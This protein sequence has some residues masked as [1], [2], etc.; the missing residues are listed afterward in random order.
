MGIDIKSF[1]ITATLDRY[2]YMRMPLDV[3]V[4]P[5]HVRDQYDLDRKAKNGFVYLEIRRAIYGLPQ[6]GALANKLLREQLAPYGY[7]EVAHTPGL[8]RHVTCPISFSLMLLMILELRMLVTNMH[9][10]SLMYSK[11]GINLQKIGMAVFI[12]VLTWIG[13]MMNK[14]WISRC[15]HIF[16]TE[17]LDTLW[18]FQTNKTAT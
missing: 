3:D 6:S 16:R 1:F 11:N 2:K 7:Y 5:R 8:W 12:V 17:G 14:M 18:T 13:I 15:Q 4:F 10:I 9:Y